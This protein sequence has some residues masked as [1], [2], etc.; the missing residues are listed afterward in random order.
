MFDNLSTAVIPATEEDILSAFGDDPKDKKDKKPADKN[1]DP[2]DS[3]TKN[4]PSGKT[5]DKKTASLPEN[6]DLVTKKNTLTDFSE[7]DDKDVFESQDDDDDD[8]EPEEDTT[9]KKVVKKKDDEEETS[10]D[11]DEDNED[12]EDAEDDTENKINDDDEEEGADAVDEEAQI[13]NFLKT[14]AE[15]LIKNGE[16]VDFEGSEDVDWTEEEFA[17]IEID[18]RNYQKQQMSDE[19]LDSFGPIGRD[20]ATY[21]QNGGDPDKLIDIFKEQQRVENLSV[22]TEDGQKAVVLK[23]QT[24]F[25]NQKSERVKKYIDSL[26]AD[27][28]LAA[29]AKE[30]KEEM[31]G[32]LT[33]QSDELQKQQD[34][35]IKSQ[36]DNQKASIQ[37]FSTDVTKLIT[38][39]ANIPE[40]EKKQ[41]IKVLTKYDK[42][43]PNGTP[44]N[45]FYQI[46]S[47]LKKDLPGYIKFVRFAINPAKY[48]KALKTKG[49]NEATDKDFKLIRTAN[50]IKKIKSKDTAPKSG[51][52][53]TK[54]QLL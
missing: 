15:F 47:D 11:D 18:Q 32:I 44:V 27:K 31:E 23:Y 20:I 7:K 52:I 26:I 39:D 54:F 53:G 24:E 21:A 25:L 28:D 17:K 10:N 30:A 3:K 49:N 38:E 42:R 41:L 22:E 51:K 35:K 12:N 33:Q 48:E 2:K 46:F 34:A 16:W 13:K 29:A 40:D 9:K 43:L 50:K 1:Q 14:R 36:R 19:I 5:K 8:D 45:E 4:Q 6:T 37:K